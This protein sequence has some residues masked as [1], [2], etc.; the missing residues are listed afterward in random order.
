MILENDHS[1]D[2]PEKP[3]DVEDSGQETLSDPAVL[4]FWRHRWVLIGGF[5]GTVLV[6]VPLAAYLWLASGP[7]SIQRVTQ[8][9]SQSLRKVL[10]ENYDFELGT[11]TIVID[12][13]RGLVAELADLSISN[14]ESKLAAQIGSLSFG[15]QAL[16]LLTG[17][18]QFRDVEIVNPSIS[19]QSTGILQSTA[20]LGSSFGPLDNSTELEADNSDL[21]YLAKVGHA[22]KSIHDASDAVLA[23]GRDRGIE[24]IT[25]IDGDVTVLS[26]KADANRSYSNIGVTLKIDTLDDKLILNANGVAARGAWRFEAQAT[27]VPDGRGHEINA[28]V[29]D[30]NLPE[31]IPALGRDTFAVRSNATTSIKMRSKYVD[32]DAVPTASFDVNIG[33]GYVFMGRNEL[34]LMDE[35]TLSLIWSPSLTAL[36]IEKAELLFG[37][38]KLSFSGF[39][40]PSSS[41]PYSEVELRLV[42]RDTILLP[43][44]VVGGNAIKPELIGINARWDFGSKF[45]VIDDFALHVADASILGSAS[46]NFQPRFPSVAGAFSLSPMSV[47]TLKRIWPPTL[48]GG[49]RR[50]FIKNVLSG[51]ITG[52]EMTLA[53]PAGFVGNRDP[54]KKMANGSVVGKISFIDAHIKSF[55]D[56]PNL[57]AES[58]VINF[59]GKGLT[60]S[61]EN[62][63]A[64]NP[65]GGVV[66]VPSAI[67]RLPQ[68]G[69]TIPDAEITV[70]MIGSAQDLAEIANSAPIKFMDKRGVPPSAV[71]GQAIAEITS[72]LKIRPKISPEDV[73]TH[74][75]VRLVNFSSTVPIQGRIISNGDVV[76]QSDK[77][78]TFVRGDAEL[79][80]IAA[81]VDLYIPNDG[82]SGLSKVDIRL[83]LDEQQRRR[84]GIDLSEFLSGPT[85]VEVGKVTPDGKRPV[86]V[87][88]EQARLDIQGIGWTKGVGIP[89]DLKFL[90]EET[91]T[92]F[93]LSD[94]V[95]SGQGFSA[96]GTAQISRRRGLER[97]T[98]KS[99][100]LRKGDKAAID[101]KRAGSRAYKIKVSGEQL[102]VRGLVRVIKRDA[103]PQENDEANSFSVNAKLR[104]L[105][106]FSEQVIDNVKLALETKGN[107]P[108]SMQLSGTQNGGRPITVSIEE[109]NGSSWLSISAQNGGSLIG[110]MDISSSVKGGNFSLSASL[111]S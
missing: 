69:P 46:V 106:G 25:I 76:V 37:P 93:E 81:V 52:G 10:P 96:S 33:S 12:P 39:A 66:D 61:A 7:V 109:G 28:R 43:R 94:I 44:D 48:A 82:A 78:G 24:S 97:L 67:F 41:N 91:D 68:I 59:E 55:G 74:T 103:G 1:E 13:F 84:L 108:S 53:I 77:A 102:D 42:S 56:L 60:I 11:V 80:G 36:S 75:T 70:S 64:E 65:I 31:L 99:L 83:V 22:L 4:P 34:A 88:L 18:M 40:R 2:A 101:I 100:A 71:S 14:S 21:F 51:Q 26:A 16:K 23:A 27:P 107:Q 5:I 9:V 62:G 111:G 35:G 92:G 15:I 87:D 79:D 8:H 58:G 3:E 90:L 63:T 19:V 45:L 85:P 6:L 73:I 30:L 49:A 86:S 104:R 72:K 17:Q 105:V 89:A 57:R 95:L 29:D 54:D 98:L 38:T 110:F 47:D 20:N 50:W 32:E